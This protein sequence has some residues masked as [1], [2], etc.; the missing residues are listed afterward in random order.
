MS[1]GPG[2]LK[3][4]NT[5]EI[6]GSPFFKVR[7]RFYH[8]DR[9][10]KHFPATTDLPSFVHNIS[11]SWSRATMVLDSGYIAKLQNLPMT[12]SGWS[13]GW[14][15]S[16]IW[17]RVGWRCDVWHVLQTS[18]RTYHYWYELE[19]LKIE[20]TSFL[21]SYC[22]Q[23][24]LIFRINFSTGPYLSLSAQLLLLRYFSNSN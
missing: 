8:Y 11:V 16:Q 6:Y 24:F 2:K 7:I 12:L 10:L 4:V 3:V 20:E 9:S 23:T 17:S 19:L 22:V 13:R 15:S 14:L 18:I 5:E 1:L 21:P